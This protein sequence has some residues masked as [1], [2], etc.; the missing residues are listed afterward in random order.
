MASPSR[1]TDRL[2]LKPLPAAAAACLPQDRDLAARLLG[3]GLPPDWP[4]A[5][6]L[7]ILPMQASAGP[8]D[9]RNGIWVMIERRTNTVVGDIGFLGPPRG[10]EVEIGFSVVPDRRRLGYATEAANALVDWGSASRE[11]TASS[12]DARRAITRPSA[13][14][15]GSGSSGPAKP[16]A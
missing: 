8:D 11:S 5:D 1:A 3:A 6:L 14:S 16:T 9:E 12:P 4:Q 13:C 7:D 2:D 10:G 15:N